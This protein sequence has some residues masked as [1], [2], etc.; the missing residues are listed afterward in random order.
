MSPRPPAA[1]G[2]TLQASL[3]EFPDAIPCTPPPCLSA[4]TRQR[5]WK[6]WETCVAGKGVKMWCFLNQYFS[7]IPVR[8]PEVPEPDHLILK[9]MGVAGG[10][11]QVNRSIMSRALA[12]KRVNT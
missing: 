3:G 9:E 2:H 8:I 4:E 1:L 7:T 10:R 12:L 6:Q 11:G 5:D